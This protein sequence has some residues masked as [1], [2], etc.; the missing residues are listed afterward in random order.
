MIPSV[1]NVTWIF[2]G[3]FCSVNS[4][5]M[6]ICQHFWGFMEKITYFSILLNIEWKIVCWKCILLIFMMNWHENER[7]NRLRFDFDIKLYSMFIQK[8]WWKILIPILLVKDS[9]KNLK[10]LSRQCFNKNIFLFLF[11]VSFLEQW[12]WVQPKVW[13]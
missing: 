6:F 7:K 2:L 9:F 12:S 13:I 8:I 5:F 3:T 10:F 1:K 11:Q 4:H